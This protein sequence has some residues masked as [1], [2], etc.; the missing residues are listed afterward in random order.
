M[1]SKQKDTL[2]IWLSD[3]HTGGTTALFPH[4]NQ[5]KDGHWKFKHI[6][7][8]PSSEQ[9]RL[10]DHFDFCADEIAKQRKNKRIIIVHNGDAID[11]RHHDSRQIITHDKEEQG[12]VHVWLMKYFFDKI[13]FNKNKGDLL[14]YVSGTETHTTD[15]EYGIA[16]DLGA[17]QTP[18]GK[19]VFEFLPLEI[20]G[21]LIYA[22]HE[23]TSSGEGYT[24]GDA[25]R[26][27]LKRLY[28]QCL[29]DKVRFPD[30]VVIS[31]VHRPLYTSYVHNYH[32]IHGMIT[33][34]WQIKTRFGNQIAPFQ[35][36]KIGMSTVDITTDG[37][38]RVNKPIL[39]SFS[40][41]VVVV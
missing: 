6:S 20:A 37:I 24:E 14:Y 9:C 27:S 13:S 3:L 29:S 15:Y 7:Y 40:D 22:A 41:E 8:P 10:F 4:Y 2:L 34:S 35:Q 5:L 18:A 17:E 28:W 1:F 21:K 26:N 32:T 31:H 30:L 12:A 19:D 23:G 16:Q 25:F 33:P 38:I 39:M 11:G 36:N